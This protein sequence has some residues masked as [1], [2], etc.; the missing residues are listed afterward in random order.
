MK[1][2]VPILIALALLP[3]ACDQAPQEQVTRQQ[4][5]IIRLPNVAGGPGVAYLDVALP[6]APGDLVSVTSA[7][8]GR[9]AMHESMMQGNM[10]TMHALDRI[11]TGGEPALHFAPG[12]RHL[13]LFDL[14]PA[15][16]PGDAVTLDFHFSG[17][18]TESFVAY[19]ARS[20]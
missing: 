19:V 12:G 5:P 14:D 16:H 17:G 18:L 7:R 8:I 3:T 1:R 4:T 10:S 2:L 11:H 15:L 6:A 20:N 13:M 9:I